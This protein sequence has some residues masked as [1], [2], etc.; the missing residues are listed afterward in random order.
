[1]KLY[2]HPPPTTVG[3]LMRPPK[4]QQSFLPPQKIMFF[5]PYTVEQ[6]ASYAPKWLLL[7]HFYCFMTIVLS[8]FFSSY[9]LTFSLHFPRRRAQLYVYYLELTAVKIE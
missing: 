2:S 1:L 7:S 8:L 3:V 5:Y 6:G 4:S 9:F